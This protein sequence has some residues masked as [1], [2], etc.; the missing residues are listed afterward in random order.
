MPVLT[1]YKEPD[2]Y[3]PPKNPDEP[4]NEYA[5]RYLFSPTRNPARDSRRSGRAL[6]LF[7]FIGSL[8]AFLVLVGNLSFEI[9]WFL[10]LASATIIVTH[11]L[12]WRR[13]EAKHRAENE[14][15]RM[16]DWSIPLPLVIILLT[17]L[18]VWLFLSNNL[19]PLM[20]TY[21]LYFL[22]GAAC[23]FLGGF[24]LFRRLKPV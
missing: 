3:E 15:L 5:V 6:V 21:I 10:W 16:W 4:P 11:F 17:L 8:I 2:D 1:T 13:V 12:A 22:P 19:N 7:G 24:F 20:Y 14:T 23:T 18:L 9:T